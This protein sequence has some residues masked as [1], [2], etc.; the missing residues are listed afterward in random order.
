MAATTKAFS[1]N[2]PPAC[3]DEDLNGFKNE[4]N[5]LITGS[6]Q[7]L[8]TAD[9]QQTQKAVAVY[10]AGGDFYA[11]SGAA[12]A[13]VLSPVGSKLAPEDYFE[14]MRVRFAPDNDN[15]GASTVNVDS[16]GVID[17]K[18]PG[19]TAD[20]SAGQI[21]AGRESEFSYRTSPGAHFELNQPSGAFRGAL[22]FLAASASIPDSATTALVLAD[23]IYDT[24]SIHDNAIN[25]SRLTVPSGV[26]RVRLIGRA[27][28]NGNSTGF[29]RLSIHKG[30]L[31]NYG[32][33]PINSELPISASVVHD[34]QVISPVLNV[35]SGDYFELYAYQT[36]GGA[37]SVIGNAT[38]ISTWFGMEIVE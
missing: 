24:D 16:L 8:S 27:S 20:P 22:A 6:G 15:T 36:S 26:T 35:T 32:G 31:G 23:E 19:G 14:G 21:V 30:G 33:V 13:Y 1:N 9:N 7:G 11:D 12:D 5:N 4:N 10:A 3:E 38:G 17:I 37:L 34:M 25:P 18:L 29:R 2:N 28:W